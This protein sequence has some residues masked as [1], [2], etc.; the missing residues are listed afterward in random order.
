MVVYS[1]IH[2]FQT[3]CISL[4][5]QK[6]KLS[7]DLNSVVIDSYGEGICLFHPHPQHPPAYITVISGY[8]P[9]F[10]ITME[11]SICLFVLYIQMLSFH[12]S[13]YDMLHM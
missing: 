8:S 3:L 5:L 7:L 11:N 6:D 12:V 2:R 4:S 9:C 1:G 13:E 10:V